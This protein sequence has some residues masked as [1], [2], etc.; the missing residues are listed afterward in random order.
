MKWWFSL[1]QHPMILI[2]DQDSQCLE[3]TP[4]WGA[5]DLWEYIDRLK[6]NLTLLDKYPTLKICYE[7]S[8]IEML[9]LAEKAPNVIESMQK[10]VENGRISF[11]NGTYSQPHLQ[12][13]GSESSLRQFQMGLRVFEDLFGYK[14][15]TYAAQETGLHEQM[16]QMLLSLGYK[17][18][19]TPGFYWAIRFFDGHEL[20]ANA[21]FRLE[22]VEYE[23]FTNWK[24][25]DGT[26]IP[27]YLILAG[28]TSD[29]ALGTEFQKDLFRCPPL[30]ADFPDMIEIDDNWVAEQSKNAEFVLLDSALRDRQ[31]VSP[32]KS[33]ARLYTYWSYVEGILA[34]SL[35]RNNKR[36]ETKITQAEAISTMASILL[37]LQPWNLDAVWSK[38]LRSQHHDVYWAGAPELRLKAIEW[39]KES[40]EESEKAIYETGKQIC[41][42]IDT[43]SIE[44]G[45]P[46][47]VFNTFPRRRRGIVKVTLEL[48]KGYMQ[49]AKIYNTEMEEVESQVIEAEPYEDGS[50]KRCIICYLADV[51]ALG[52]A[53]YI[54]KPAPKSL[55]EQYGTS[56]ILKFENEWY[57]AEINPDGTFESLFHKA[58]GSELL[59]VSEY[60]GNEIKARLGGTGEWITTGGASREAEVSNGPVFTSLRTQGEFGRSKFQA[61]VLLYKHLPRI[62]FDASFNFDAAIY[63]TFIDDESKMNVYWPLSFDGNI[64]HD[65]P[66]GV[67]QR[68][69][70]RPLFAINWLDLSDGVKGFA[71]IN[72][73]TPKHWVRNNVIANLLA[74][75]GTKIT[76]RC[77]AKVWWNKEFDLRLCGNHTFNYSVFCH[78]GDWIGGD[79]ANEARRYIEP[80][81]PFPTSSHVGR[82]PNSLELL[83]IGSKSIMSTAVQRIKNGMRVRMYETCGKTVQPDVEMNSLFNK[84]ESTTLRGENVEM[85]KPFQ[86]VHIDLLIGQ[87]ST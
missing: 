75:G 43:R 33:T 32:P 54:V 18:A 12:V 25:I 5:K 55:I 37:N 63:G 52:Y 57:R 27:L 85:V 40:V 13:F 29:I 59:D 71:Y 86:I 17:F 50:L 70:S 30:K 48:E 69:T 31:K 7:I 66:F 49:S 79:V 64:Y 67:V 84:I 45:R 8:G 42:N 62:D 15:D 44:E 76:N 83:N 11:L 35:S 87:K 61:T 38:I 23:E 20:I 34:E 22:P 14:V 47:I 72:K 46:I 39:L 19:V 77:T 26:T 6:R 21:H 73:G 16:P 51:P 53:A 68:R 2:I 74:W 82:L 24:G 41:N 36:A 80:L 1:C 81:I 78:N 58:S 4:P 10:F 28:G 60:S 65:I 9:D 56:G 3:R